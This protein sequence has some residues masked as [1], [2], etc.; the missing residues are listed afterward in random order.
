MIK[1]K[2][3]LSLLLALCLAVT[4]IPTAAYGAEDVS[5]DIV[6]L[7][8]GD[9][10]GGVDANISLA[11]LRAYA[12]ER[13]AKSKYLEIVDAGDALS[14]TALANASKG[15]FVVEAMNEAG[16]A[17]AV[18]GVHDFDFGVN[19][20]V[21]ELAPMADFEYVSCNFTDIETWETAFKPY[22]IVTYGDTKVAYVG[23]SDPA[24]MSK[25]SA[26]FAENSGGGK[27]NFIYGGDGKYLYSIVQ[28]AVDMAKR[29]GADYVVAIGHLDSQGEAAYTPKSVIANTT[30]INAFIA[31]NSHSSIVGQQVKDKDGK[32]VLLTSAGSG[33]K[34]IG[35]LTITPGKNISS[36]L[37][38]NYAYRYIKTST[39]IRSLEQKYAASLKETVASSEVKLNSANSD[40]IRTIGSSETNL[41]DLCAD[42]YRAV[43]GADIALVEASE[44]EGEIAAGDIS[45]ADIERVMP[46]NASI[47]MF[48]VS[49]GEIL[50][51]LEMAARL[52][53]AT[54]EG[55][56]QVSGLSFDIQETVK[57]SVTVDSKGNFTGVQ[58]EY[59]VTNVMIGS[60]ELDLM[61][62]YTVAATED[63]LTG[64]TGY[65]MFEDVSKKVTGITTDNQALYQYITKDLKGKISA[66]YENKAGRIDYIKLARQSQIDAEIEAGVT[67]K[68]K[69]Y[70]QEMAALREKIELQNQIIAVRSVAIKASSSLKKSGSTR[71]VKLSWSLSQD[72]D[73]MKYQIYKSTK[74]NSGYSKIY[75]T[76]KQT[77][78]NTSGLTKG[79]TYYYKVRG[80][81]YINGKYYYTDWANI[82]YRTIL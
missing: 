20:L 11:G 55:F 24:T 41:G 49:G 29:D 12:N 27:Y 35:V 67:E 81:K 19:T 66:A 3:M 57:S 61:G 39:A 26:G 58:K 53:P 70:S 68:I 65:T 21:D 25:S 37:V 32:S 69:N 62:D 47:S 60:K 54:N 64:A 48:T 42:A 13:Q 38:S 43:T 77:F 16:Y 56:L 82:C 30:G 4:M 7:Y 72:I 40:G 34:N 23:I 9:I 79:K 10:H 14:G 52:F 63:F 31:G 76:S 73:G 18:P 74:K 59:R 80:Y 50:D 71:K 17:I 28:Y 44:I 46:A 75:T 33:L 15:K 6:I 5:E 78:T 22:E 8:T 1:K 51:A 36:Q 2:A 45:Y